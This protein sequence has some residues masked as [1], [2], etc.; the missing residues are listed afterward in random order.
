MTPLVRRLAALEQA[1]PA[2]PPARRPVVAG[3]PTFDRAR[4]EAFL[5]D[6]GLRGVDAG[7]VIYIGIVSP[8]GEPKW[9]EMDLL[10]PTQTDQ[11]GHKWGSDQELL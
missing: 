10:S 9:T 6:R 8:R 3:P 4:V 2:S 11:T 1:N 5:A 7:E